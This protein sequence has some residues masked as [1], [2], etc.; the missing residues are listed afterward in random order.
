MSTPLAAGPSAVATAGR[1]PRVLIADDEP[2]V[3]AAITAQLNG[4]FEIVG[5]A[6]DADG[7]IAIAQDCQPDVALIDVEM[8]RA[9]PG[10]AGPPQ[11]RSGRRR[12]RSPRS[13]RALPRR[14]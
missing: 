8:R 5:Q 12:D 11:P 1:R 2:V 13:R 4:H 14:L 9:P 6:D 7:A 10:G 3:R